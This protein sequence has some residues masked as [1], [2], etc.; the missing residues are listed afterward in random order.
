LAAIALLLSLAGCYDTAA[1]L[2]ARQDSRDLNQMDEVDLGAYRITLP[3][4]LG[5]ATD[6]L[7]DFHV[8]GQVTRG[9]RQAI[10]D[11]L[12]MRGAELRAKLL[13]EVRSMDLHA[14]EEAQLAT[15][16]SAIAAVIND[17]L[18]RRVVKQVG[19]YRFSFNTI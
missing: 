7:I 8:F 16:R 3:H 10:D 14:F 4:T 1:L 17:T 9:D 2:K 11:A 12:Q 5:E 15:L 6:N 19:F 18:G 13:V